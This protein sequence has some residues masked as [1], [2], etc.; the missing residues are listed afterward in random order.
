MIKDIVLLRIKGQEL[1]HLGVSPI[2]TPFRRDYHAVVSS[3]FQYELYPP[4]TKA[5][6]TCFH[7]SVNYHFLLRY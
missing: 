4:P 2:I 1:D 5:F 3:K 7:R 6:D